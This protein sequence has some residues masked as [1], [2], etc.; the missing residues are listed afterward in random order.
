MVKIVIKENQEKPTVSN[1]EKGFWKG[2][3]INHSV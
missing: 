1:Q 2:R 3:S